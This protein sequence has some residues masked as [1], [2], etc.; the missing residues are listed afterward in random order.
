[1]TN[2][3]HASVRGLRSTMVQ[4]AEILG[5]M[6]TMIEALGVQL[7]L[8]PVVA[9]AHGAELQ[10]IDHTSQKLRAIADLLQ[11]DCQLTFDKLGIK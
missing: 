9:G 8:D 11:A 5:E 10:A 7:C 2:S 6:S 4:S 3:D 1:M